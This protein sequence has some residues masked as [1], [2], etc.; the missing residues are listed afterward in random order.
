VLGPDHPDTL[1]TRG[2]VAYYTGEGGDPA[3][4]LELYRELLTDQQRVLGP[5]HPDT[6]LTRYRLA[7]VLQS[8][9]QLDEQAE[10]EYRAVLAAETERL[11]VDHPDTMVTRFELAGVLQQ[12]GDRDAAL[13]EYS[14]C[15]ARTT[16][17]PWPPAVGSMRWRR[18]PS[19]LS[20]PAEGDQY[21]AR[22]LELVMDQIS[23]RG[24]KRTSQVS[25]SERPRRIRALV[26]LSWAPEGS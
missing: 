21:R 5:D 4:A 23:G 9:G 16:P 19:R 24:A 8:Q 7:G 17:T 25:S 11:G 26:I 1:V 10:A 18:F 2:Q 13:A 15:S 22:G 12:R 3:G 6:V 14:G 20:I